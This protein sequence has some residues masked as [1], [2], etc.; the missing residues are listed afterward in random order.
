MVAKARKA[1]PSCKA[2]TLVG[3]PGKDIVSTQEA[4]P[5]REACAPVLDCLG[6]LPDVPE[7]VAEML[8]IALPV[9]L[10]TAKPKRHRYEVCVISTATDILDDAEAKLRDAIAAAEDGG[11]KVASELAA[12][13]NKIEAAAATA[14]AKKESSSVA[15]RAHAVACEAASGAK[16]AAAAAKTAMES[17]ASEQAAVIAK[18]DECQGAL[19]RLWEPLKLLEEWCEIPKSLAGALPVAIKT[20]T[21]ERGEFAMQTLEAGEAVHNQ[22]LAELSER[23]AGFDAENSQHAATVSNAERVLAES[24]AAM[25]EAMEESNA[26]QNEWADAQTIVDGLKRQQQALGLSE[27]DAAK[28]VAAAHGALEDLHEVSEKLVAMRDG[29][30]TGPD[31]VPETVP[32]ADT[33]EAEMAEPREADVSGAAVP[34]E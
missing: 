24:D 6:G 3:E 2:T 9:A 33:E 31:A 22:H 15:E 21:N 17:L 30:P 25:E 7:V 11:V 29:S 28:D 23:I 1:E 10:N 18:R 5:I 19:G 16:E 8:N 27:I 13:A 32:M 14:A 12:I 20:K 4:D 34:E 26:R